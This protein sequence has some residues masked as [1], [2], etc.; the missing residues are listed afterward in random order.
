M[1]E[2]KKGGKCLCCLVIGIILIV[3]GA[4]A[5]YIGLGAVEGF[6][7]KQVAI[8]IL[9]VVLALFGM[10]TCKLGKCCDKK[11]NT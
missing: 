10:G 8:V 2:E 11:D 7:P 6:G 3:V 9:G 4:S 5:D 1:A